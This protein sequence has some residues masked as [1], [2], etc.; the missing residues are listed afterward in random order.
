MILLWLKVCLTAAGS[1]TGC[2]YG[3]P[4]AGNMMPGPARRIAYLEAR[5]GLIKMKSGIPILFNFI[6]LFAGICCGYHARGSGQAEEDVRAAGAAA[7]FPRNAGQGVQKSRGNG[8]GSLSGYLPVRLLPK[9]KP[10]S[11]TPRN[12]FAFVPACPKTSPCV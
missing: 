6:V 3:W 1:G 11:S 2:L 12:W 7:Q 4:V 10:N 8:R 9:M 5:V